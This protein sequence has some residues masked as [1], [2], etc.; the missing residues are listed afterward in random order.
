M[1]TTKGVKVPDRLA[2][3]S[4]IAFPVRLPPI[5]D[6]YQ[7]SK[8]EVGQSFLIPYPPLSDRRLRAY[9]Q[10]RVGG[11]IAE[12]HRQLPARR[13]SQRSNRDGVR[14]WRIK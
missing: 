14:V 1:L 10:Q 11:I 7:F 2:T 5:V 13:F 9:L 6:R 8:L 4:G 3:E 12:A